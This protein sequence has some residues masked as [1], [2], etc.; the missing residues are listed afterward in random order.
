MK[1]FVQGIIQVL[2]KWERACNEKRN[3][4]ADA[5]VM[6]GEHDN[7]AKLDMKTSAEM[8][9]ILRALGLSDFIKALP[10]SLGEKVEAL[11]KQKLQAFAP[12][13]LFPKEL[14]KV[15]EPPADTIDTSDLFPDDEEDGDIEVEFVG[16][17]FE[18]KCVS[19]PAVIHLR[20]APSEPEPL[21][22]SNRRKIRD[23]KQGNSV[24]TVKTGANEG[25]D[26]DGEG[27]GDEGGGNDRAS[28]PT[29]LK[30][31]NP[32]NGPITPLMELQWQRMNP[33]G[34]RPWNLNVYSRRYRVP[35]QYNQS[36]EPINPQA[37]NVSEILR[38]MGVIIKKGDGPLQFGSSFECGNLSQAHIIFEREYDLRCLE[39]YNTCGHTQWYYFSVTNMEKDVPYKFNI[40]NFGKS[41]SL[42]NDG[43]LPVF[44]STKLAETTG[45]G[46][47]RAGTNV[48]YF[49]GMPTGGKGAYWAS[50]TMTFPVEDDICYLAYGVPYTMTDLRADLSLWARD[51][52]TDICRRETLCKSLGGVDM[53]MLTVGKE[54]G[55]LIS[56]VGE[57]GFRK[58]VVAI[59]ARVHPGEANSSWMMK[60]C[61]EY[62]LGDSPGAAALRE[63]YTFKFL[64]MLNPDGVMLGNYRCS[65]A[66]LDLNRQWHKPNRKITPEI[67]YWK[68]YMKKIQESYCL[69]LPEKVLGVPTGPSGPP[70]GSIEHAAGSSGK[71]IF[72]CDLHGHSRKMDSFMYGCNNAT[73]A[74]EKIF[75]FLFSKVNPHLFNFEECRFK[76]QKSK[77]G[78]GR[79]VG[80]KELGVTSCFTLEA[81]FA[82][83]SIGQNIGNH[84]SISDL[85]DIGKSL[86]TAIQSWGDLLN[87]PESKAE[88][89]REVQVTI[90]EAKKARVSNNGYSCDEG[91]VSSAGSD[92]DPVSGN[93]GAQELAQRWAHMLKPEDSKGK[94]ADTEDATPLLLDQPNS[95]SNLLLL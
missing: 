43:M 31:P 21:S 56:E 52:N 71:L 88:T 39:D 15:D 67:Y 89:T 74:D 82:G 45:Q 65:L 64:P 73:H 12:K 58:P 7:V 86:V 42:Y 27:S 78:T 23:Q 28:M 9:S 40:V 41:D 62:L 36:E 44:Y 55:P 3:R 25:D 76:V 16:D 93:L 57:V 24:A 4:L 72:Y 30:P 34:R 47:I 59:S 37:P 84:M 13:A 32:A 70:R 68:N 75:P 66:G 35:H 87:K 1:E 8:C 94:K 51:E 60:G 6:Q 20:H 49:K 77:R 5:G 50:F 46:W 29:M 14:L 22:E 81:T 19:Y 63:Q 61:I 38:M 85:E 11:R 18:Q 79:V 92:E 95:Y 10:L 54:L 2:Q 53:D 69:G 91:E 90:V 48:K 33:T 83:S 26:D 17:G 80:W